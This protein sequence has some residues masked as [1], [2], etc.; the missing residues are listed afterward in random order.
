MSPF[1][2]S[3][4]SQIGVPVL[5][6]LSLFL[7]NNF[8]LASVLT[9][10]PGGTALAVTDFATVALVVSPRRFASVTLIYA[11]YAF[12]AVL[13]H[14]GVDA[15]A[16]LRHVP[17][18][19]GAAFIFDAV[20]ALGRYRWLALA[21]GVLPFAA[22]VSFTQRVPPSGPRFLAALALAYAGLAI[23]ALL[24]HASARPAAAARWPA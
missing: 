15:V 20:I 14:V 12:L 6:G 23:G 19:V 21:V 2:R 9:R 16:H 22:I 13:G 5:A 3:T 11:T 10:L 18:L 1:G 17:I 24:P 7:V 4:F 8:L